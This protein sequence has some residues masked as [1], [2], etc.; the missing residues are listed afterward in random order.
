[1]FVT[2]EVLRYMSMPYEQ[3]DDD[4]KADIL[5]T[6]EQLKQKCAP[7]V[8]L[9][10]F[11]I[12]HT[13]NGIVISTNNFYIEGQDILRTMKNAN[14]MYVMVATLGMGADM[15]I[16]QT[17]SL[18]M[19][20]ALIV[21]SCCNVLIESVCDNAE[22]EIIEKLNDN[23]HLTMRYSPGYG[24]VPLTIQDGILA[25]MMAGKRIGLSTTKSGML[26][27]TKSVTAFIGVSNQKEDRLRSCSSCAMKGTCKYRK[28]GDRCGH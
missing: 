21:N 10:L 17:Q 27:P 26:V 14:K 15:F 5:D 13:D 19:S 1:M 22:R 8:L 2:K 23:E 28:R 12:S 9:E 20:Q 24:D 3:A 11:D 6:Y 18:S 16:R 25:M 7:K 4:M